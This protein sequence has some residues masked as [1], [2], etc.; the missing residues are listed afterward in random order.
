MACCCSVSVTIFFVISVVFKYAQLTDQTQQQEGMSPQERHDY[1]PPYVTLSA[2][3]M[4]LSVSAIV[5]LALLAMINFLKQKGLF[6]KMYIDATTG[7][8]NKAYFVEAR[9]NLDPSASY[10]F[11]SMDIQGFKA[12]NDNI[13][14]E[15]GDEALKWWGDTVKDKTKS[16]AHCKMTAYRPGGDEIAIICEKH[17]DAS[18]QAFRAEVLDL[19]KVLAAVS[20]GPEGLNPAGESVKVDTFL[21]I[22]AADEFQLADELETAVRTRVYMAA[23]GSLDA[24]GKFVQLAS[25]EDMRIC[26][27]EVQETMVAVK[28]EVEAMSVAVKD[29]ALRA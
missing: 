18:M 25:L 21:R 19:V 9:A 24:R 5:I 26:N 7:L 22:G 12:V 28:G 1:M 13:S 10:L 16:P 11:L 17:G 3:A 2:I 29:V 14:H 23:F 15:K 6:N 4:A 8:Y 20:H 27:W